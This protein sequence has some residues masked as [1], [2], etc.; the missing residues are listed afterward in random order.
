MNEDEGAFSFN[1]FDINHVLERGTELLS[2]AGN[3]FEQVRMAMQRWCLLR[4]CSM[5]NDGLYE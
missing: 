2:C 5:G 1:K 4:K 3:E